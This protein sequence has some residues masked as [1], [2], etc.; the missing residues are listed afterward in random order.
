MRRFI[1]NLSKLGGPAMS[2]KWFAEKY[3]EP[4]VEG[5]TVTRAEGLL[6]AGACFVSRN[7]PMH[8][9]VPYLRNNLQGETDILQEYYVPRR[10]LTAFIDGARRIFREQR[11][12]VLNASVR[13]VHRETITLNYAPEDMFALVLYLNQR[14]DEAG[15]VAMRRLTQSLID[16]AA[17]MGGTFFLPYQLHYTAAQLERAY[18]RIGEFFRAKR[19]YDPDGLL[20]NTWHETYNRSFF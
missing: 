12:N 3:I 5:C 20:T 2:A 13:V 7:E 17:T 19:R 14:T 15:T 18:P 6:E 11:A 8:D 4:K 10:Q 9:S 16:L 1:F